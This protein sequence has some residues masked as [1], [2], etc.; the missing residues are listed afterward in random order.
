M[1]QHVQ[2]GIKFRLVQGKVLITDRSSKNPI[3]AKSGM[4]LPLRGANYMIVTGVAS[5]AEIG[6]S[7]TSIP[8]GPESVMCIGPKGHSEVHSHRVKI[9]VGRLWARLLGWFGKDDWAEQNI[10]NDAPGVRG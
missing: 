9:F 6:L 5:R 7:D 8:M 3:E 1:S 10:P 4:Y 2:S